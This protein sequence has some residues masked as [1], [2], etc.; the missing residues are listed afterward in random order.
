MQALGQGPVVEREAELTT[1]TRITRRAAAGRGSVLAVTGS[2]GIG[3]TRLLEQVASDAT[4]AGWSVLM[5]RAPRI[6][7]RRSTLGV[8]LEGLDPRAHPLDGPAR[9]LGS[10]LA[11]DPTTVGSGPAPHPDL[12][13]G[14][15]WLLADLTA[16]R[17]VLL[18]VD[19][20]D[21]AD[22]STI[23]V[24]HALHDDVRSTRCVLAVSATDDEPGTPSRPE[25]RGPLISFVADA[26][27]VPLSPLSRGGVTRLAGV[28]QP[29]LDDDALAATYARTRG[30]P[31][32]VTD[33]LRSGA[34][35]GQRRSAT[36][37]TQELSTAE[38]ELLRLVCL[39]DDRP[40]I[41]EVLA[42]A[43]GDQVRTR[44]ALDRLVAGEL[45]TIDPPYIA[46]AGPRVR[47]AVLAET[48]R[49]VA[50]LLHDRLAQALISRGASSGRVVPHLLQTRPHTDPVARAALAEAG[51]AALA[52]G[53]DRLATALLQRALDE[54]PHGADDAPLHADIA[55]ALASLGDLDAALASWTRARALAV[56]PALEIGYA[57]EAA[58]ALAD[59]GRQPDR[60]IRV[61][62]AF[63][64][65][66]RSREHATVAEL[67]LTVAEDVAAG[68]RPARVLMPAAV[69][70]VASSAFDA[71]DDVLT[72][73][74]DHANG[75]PD[76][77]SDA[78]VVAACRG[79][80]R[81]R[82][83]R[84]T[85]GLADLEVAARGPESLAAG[86]AAAHLTVVIEARLARGEL[87]EAVGLA[88]DLARRPAGR[89]L[90]GGLIRH[91]LAEVASA[92]GH[93]QR[94]LE[95]YRDAGHTTGLHLDNPGLL[96]WRVGAAFA[97][98]R[99][100]G[101]GRAPALA[102]ENL[103]LAQ[104]FGAPYAEA[105]ALRTVAAVDV[106]ADRV[107][108]LRA[109]VERAGPAGA[110]RLQ[111]LVATDLA[112]M[113][114]LFPNEQEEAVA[115][116]R[117]ADSYATGESLAPL[118]QRAR[119]LLDRLGAGPGR[120]REEEL[121]T[122][123]TGER[124]TARLAADGHTNQDIADRLGVSVKAVEWHLSSS[125]R[126]LGIRSRRQ[127]PALFGTA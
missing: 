31:R 89:G 24:L 1:F 35:G 85:D 86:H 119:R 40:E 15:R 97:E 56:D 30:N 17:P 82:A 2:A 73:A 9:A 8:L 95:L 75:R 109:A 29:G 21:Y 122:L 32:S 25:T 53:D 80:A 121:A 69:L 125:Y 46:P 10:L 22:A 116:L 87:A 50:G 98:M 64:L 65:A 115:L 118:Q 110:P 55:R 44:A 96:P 6:R 68:R 77:R 101:A 102:R 19:D 74:L 39:V 88:D 18:V 114:A 78:M 103:Q 47:T 20:L 120:R 94:A 72:T 5:A 83:G 79:F 127:L 107:G 26:R 4:A 16:L 99:C 23:R 123:T 11:P 105:Q 14:L 76:G 43:G 84:V 62:A 45:V 51:R 92:Q 71:A 42:A 91:A 93:D 111:H 28:W 61:A 13:L 52:D 7:A 63:A 106:T 126:K 3:K 90:A 113:L 41:D 27:R 66:A 81:V 57:A 38:T 34:L 36:P 33:L 48:P 58:D 54:G 67:A 70:L 117:D 49:A 100:G 124:R 104:Q 37:S 12:V 60:S 59:A 112:S 108:L